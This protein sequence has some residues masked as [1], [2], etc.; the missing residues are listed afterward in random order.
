[1]ALKQ[2]GKAVLKPGTEDEAWGL[3]KSMEWGQ[4]ADKEEIQDGEGDTVGVLYKNT[5]KKVTGE[6]TP[7]AAAAETDP[8]MKDDL[9]GE[10]LTFD[11]VA[12]LI[13][14][15]SLKRQQ[16]AS[17]TFSISGTYYPSLDVSAPAGG[18]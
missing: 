14:T 11:G 16:G 17:S 4:E 9:I 8:P 15:A 13:E 1:M 10:T 7:L 3:C 5:R 2:K 18:E 6:F 12:I